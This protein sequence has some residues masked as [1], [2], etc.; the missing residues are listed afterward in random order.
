MRVAVLG[1]DED[2]VV[3]GSGVTRRASGERPDQQ[4]SPGDARPL[5]PVRSPSSVAAMAAPAG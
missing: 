1:G 3:D 4:L 5:G 2:L